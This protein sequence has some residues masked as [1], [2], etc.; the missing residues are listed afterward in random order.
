M[1]YDLLFSQIFMSKGLAVRLKEHLVRLIELH[2]RN[3]KSYKK[4]VGTGQCARLMER[5]FNGAVTVLLFLSKV[6]RLC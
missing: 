2:L 4:N 1:I 3:Y 6:F 5:P